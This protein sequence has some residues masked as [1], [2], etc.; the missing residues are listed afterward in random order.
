MPPIR[1]LGDTLQDMVRLGVAG[2][3]L[4]PCLYI[5]AQGR[6]GEIG[7][8]DHRRHRPVRSNDMESLGVVERVAQCNDGQA[9]ACLPAHDGENR[10]DVLD[11]QRIGEVGAEHE[12]QGAVFTGQPPQDA[13]VLRQS[14]VPEEPGLHPERLD[15]FNDMVIE[16]LARTVHSGPS[17]AVSI[18]QHEAWPR[19][20]GNAQ[21]CTPT[22]GLGE[23]SAHV[24]TGVVDGR[25]TAGVASAPVPAWSHPGCPSACRWLACCAANRR[26]REQGRCCRQWP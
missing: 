15:A 21:K 26:R 8:A 18:A 12:A 10:L 23:R 19:S 11:R 17:G 20:D 4:D 2:L 14:G 5:G 16:P 7:G 9:A 13:L 22:S 1:G 24:G 6:H 3:R 25:F